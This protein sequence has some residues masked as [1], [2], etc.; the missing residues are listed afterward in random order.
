MTQDF[1]TFADPVL[2]R[3]LLA[4]SRAELGRLL[5]LGGGAGLPDHSAMDQ[6]WGLF[7]T[8]RVG[9]NLRG[10]IG[11]IVGRLPLRE[12][13]P[14]LTRAAAFEDP[15]FPPVRAGEFG[16]IRIELS[17]LSPPEPVGGWRDIEIG[18]HG[19]I[20]SLLGRQAVFLP[21]V[22]TEQGWGLE[23]TLSALSRKAGL[24]PAAWR[25]PD[26]RFQ[27]FEAVHFAE[28]P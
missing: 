9:E 12:A 13:L 6:S 11:H 28:E 2:R 27:V 1:T 22:A 8:L 25:S 18:R 10:C 5:G 23:E 24:E 4:A 14:E 19:M 21:Q 3:G 17:L 15:R 20:L 26:C 16:Q 7:V